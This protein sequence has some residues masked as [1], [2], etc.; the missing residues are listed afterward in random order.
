M[1]HTPGIAHKVAD[2]LSRVSDPTGGTGVDRPA[3]DD[4]LLVEVPPRPRQC[5]KSCRRPLQHRRRACRVSQCPH[6]SPRHT[7]QSGSR[8]N[9]NARSVVAEPPQH[10]PP[11]RI[12]LPNKTT[13]FA[14]PMCAPMP[15]HAIMRCT[16]VD[17]RGRCHPPNTGAH[18]QLWRAGAA[19]SMPPVFGVSAIIPGAQPPNCAD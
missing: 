18:K 4:S 15:G 5:R 14:P 3:L 7:N 13:G 17:G 8:D 19:G 6:A 1:L 10:T 12:R 2:H 9:Q 11:A 16:V